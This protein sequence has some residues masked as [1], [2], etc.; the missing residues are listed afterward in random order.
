MP[1]SAG[2]VLPGVEAVRDAEGGGRPR[3]QLREPAGPFGRNR[4]RIEG[5]FGPDHGLDQGRADA[6]FPRD[7]P[8]VVGICCRSGRSESQPTGGRA[9]PSGQGPV[10][11][12]RGDIGEV[13]DPFAVDEAEATRGRLARPD[14]HRHERGA[15]EDRRQGVRKAV[16]VHDG[17]TLAEETDRLQ[18][19]NRSRRGDLRRFP[20]SRRGI[21]RTG[22]SMILTRERCGHGMISRAI[23]AGR[24]NGGPNPQERT[25]RRWVGTSEM[26]ASVCGGGIVIVP[27]GLSSGYGSGS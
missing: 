11:R 14:R 7:F 9:G 10:P 25:E 19:T 3:H 15:Q 2:D 5:R 6:E 22:G 23:P 1:H 17:S 27:A 18:V 16:T 8:D 13:D 4:R 20:G 12:I 26:D 21:R 24:R